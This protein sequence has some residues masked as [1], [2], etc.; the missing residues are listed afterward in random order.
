VPL[1]SLP[2][3]VEID[4]RDERFSERHAGDA[5]EVLGTRGFREGD[6]LRRIHWPQSARHQRL[7]VCERQA[8]A[9]CAVTLAVNL[10]PCAYVGCEGACLEQVIR[11]AASVCESLH[12]QHADVECRIGHELFRI[13]G[14]AS[15]L[16]RLM[17][18]LA[19]VPRGG[20]LH[21]V[22][23]PA[24]TSRIRSRLAIVVTTDLVAAAHHG[25]HRVCPPQR[26]IVVRTE[27]Q[28]AAESADLSAGCHPWIEVG[29]VCDLATELPQRWRRACC[30]A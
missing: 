12:R 22:G 3:A 5:G 15:G 16:R 9:T 29:S 19:R 14:S 18:F 27:R 23:V 30:V 17:D 6:S 28:A 26:L 2:D 10:E 4:P 20:M 1:H 7:I 11:V 21:A 25:D 8:P 24:A 13:G